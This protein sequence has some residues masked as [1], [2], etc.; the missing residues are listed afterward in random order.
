MFGILSFMYTF[1]LPNKVPAWYVLRQFGLRYDRR[2]ILERKG[3]YEFFKLYEGFFS[4]WKLHSRRCFLVR[5]MRCVLDMHWKVNWP[6]FRHYQEMSIHDIA[7][8]SFRCSLSQCQDN[9]FQRGFA[10]DKN[11]LI[12]TFLYNCLLMMH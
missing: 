11:W 7:F 9:C 5:H 8:T 12:V 2:F 6:E 4:L 3:I 1:S 10:S